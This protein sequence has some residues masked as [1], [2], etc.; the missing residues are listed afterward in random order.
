MNLT[1]V[2][3]QCTTCHEPLDHQEVFWQTR[4]PYCSPACA[5][6]TS[7]FKPSASLVTATAL[8][9]IDTLLQRHHLQIVQGTAWR[10]VTHASG[11]LRLLRRHQLIW[12]DWAPPQ[13]TWYFARCQPGR[14]SRIARILRQVGATVWWPRY[15]DYRIHWQDPE[16]QEFIRP[17]ALHP[18]LLWIAGDSDPLVFWQQWLVWQKRATAGSSLSTVDSLWGLLLQAAVPVQ[19]HRQ[20]WLPYL[21]PAHPDRW[22]P[23]TPIV[24]RR[25][26]HRGA[27]GFIHHN[28]QLSRDRLDIIPWR[29]L[30]GLLYDSLV[31]DVHLA[32]GQPGGRVYIAQGPHAGR[33]G[34]LWG[35]KMP[36]QILVQPDSEFHTHPWIVKYS[37]CLVE[38]VHL[39]GCL[40]VR[41]T[42]LAHWLQT[43]TESTTTGLLAPDGLDSAK[44]VL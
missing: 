20:S 40:P 29:G 5:P 42:P 34:R 43:L 9:H 30:D 15:L 22:G 26:P 39:S 17:R 38:P 31:S 18:G 23:G 13:E 24:L 25:G 6:P 16:P 21:L 7:P 11:A 12:L 1:K 37:A 14:E 28:V 33:F 3:R 27:M 35:V 19:W 4:Q 41:Q 36:D 2:L 10:A 44:D 8:K 32:T